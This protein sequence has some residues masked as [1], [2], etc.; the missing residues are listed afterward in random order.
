LASKRLYRSSR[1]RILGGVSGGLA[2]YFDVDPTLVRLAWVLLA[3]SGVGVLA[4][5]VA[6]VLMP[7]APWRSRGARENGAQSRGPASAEMTV[8]ATPEPEEAQS[9]PETGQHREYRYGIP[10]GAWV[11]GLILVVVGVFLLLRNFIP[12]LWALPFWPLLIILAGVA[13]L[14]G[15][16]RSGRDSEDEG[17]GRP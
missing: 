17:K 16:F 8:E 15:A 10:S 12:L 7:E 14:V 1:E 3:F 2:D 5:L 13:L 11:M 6:W 4:Y 9:R